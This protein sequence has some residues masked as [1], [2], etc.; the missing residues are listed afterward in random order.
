MKFEQ[1]RRGSIAS[2]ADLRVRLGRREDQEFIERMN[3][4]AGA[5]RPSD[6]VARPL[7][8]RGIR[9][10]LDRRLGYVLAVGEAYNAAVEKDLIQAFTDAMDAASFDL[11]ALKDGEAVG[12]VSV[13]ASSDLAFGLLE[14][15]GNQGQHQVLSLLMGLP[16]LISVTV[17]ESER[18]RGYGADLLSTTRKIVSRMG[19][20]GLYGQCHDQGGLV[21]FYE[22]AGLTVLDRGQQ[23]N[24]FPIGGSHIVTKQPGDPSEGPF[25][26]AQDG[27]RIFY[28][29]GGHRQQSPSQKMLMQLNVPAGADS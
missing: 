18:G 19:C 27:Y 26:G 28:G 15:L 24:A 21:R 29:L 23:L 3:S 14:S 25:I 2:G 12:L 5:Q 22:S 11:V 17:E 8:Q 16:K 13:G 6:R 9:T 10:A 4:A 1:L 7:Y 20:V